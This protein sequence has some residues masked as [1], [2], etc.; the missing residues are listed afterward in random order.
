M[1]TA[2]VTVIVTVIITAM[3]TVTVTVLLQCRRQ[4][5]ASDL[6]TC[7]RLHS[8]H[9]PVT[10]THGKFLNLNGGQMENTMRVCYC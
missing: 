7:I 5:H 10:F 8:V 9:W 4:H 1:A 2:M 6:A 3:V